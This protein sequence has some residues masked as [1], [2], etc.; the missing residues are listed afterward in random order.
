M[1]CFLGIKE[2]A[3]PILR[4]LRIFY[5]KNKYEEVTNFNLNKNFKDCEYIICFSL[6]LLFDTWL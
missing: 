4:I 1:I 3:A 5:I 6:L 2:K